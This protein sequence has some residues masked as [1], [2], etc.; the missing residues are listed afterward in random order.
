MTKGRVG[1]QPVSPPLF[2]RKDSRASSRPQQRRLPLEQSACRATSPG[3]DTKPTHPREALR[4]GRRG[5]PKAEP[6]GVVVDL[7][8]KQK[9][10]AGS[11]SFPEALLGS[12]DAWGRRSQCT[13]TG[14]GS[15]TRLHGPT[16][17]AGPTPTLASRGG[18]TH[19]LFLNQGSGYSV[20]GS[21]KVTGR[22]LFEFML[23]NA[24]GNAATP[25]TGRVLL[26][27]T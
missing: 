21:C 27:T 13:H 16:S 25:M 23:F 20:S 15:Q 26:D 11:V 3:D 8:M 6:L 18:L 4:H 1:P 22:F 5:Q 10:Q 14:S 7:L 12:S 24:N 2:F 9:P 17:S 19:D